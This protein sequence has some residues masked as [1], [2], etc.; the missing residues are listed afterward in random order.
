MK[1][2]RSIR[3]ILFGVIVVGVLVWAKG[4]VHGDG[5]VSTCVYPDPCNG[6]YLVYVPEM[7]KP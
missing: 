1:A 6:Q 2:Q 4:R 5:P 7:R 3:W